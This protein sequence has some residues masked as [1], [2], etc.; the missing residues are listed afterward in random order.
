MS[1]RSGSKFYYFGDKM[2]N[3]LIV[4]DDNSARLVTK[5]HLKSEYGVVEAS[6]GEEALQK[7]FIKD[8]SHEFKT[9]INSIKGMAG[10][11]YR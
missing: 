4:E 11:A 7:Q 3:I 9:P 8:F 5:L 6:N 2:I 1:E 10:E